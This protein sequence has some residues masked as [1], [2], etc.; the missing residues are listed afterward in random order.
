MSSDRKD[1][2]PDEDVVTR[3]RRL[4]VELDADDELYDAS[5][6]AMLCDEVERHAEM[7]DDIVARLRKRAKD[8]PTWP[9]VCE[10]CLEAADEIERLRERVDNLQS[11]L[12]R[13]ADALERRNELQWGHRDGTEAESS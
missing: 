12:K 11:N 6:V 2:F 10:M 4:V 7:T 5:T 1:A 3:G 9:A 13:I 8:W